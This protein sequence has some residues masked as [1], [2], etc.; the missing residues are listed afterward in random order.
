MES[1]FAQ[2]DTLDAASGDSRGQVWWQSLGASLIPR[3]LALARGYDQAELALGS[4][5]QC[6]ALSA[7]LEIACRACQ[8]D[9]RPPSQK[10]PARPQRRSH[11][12]AF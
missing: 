3:G 7:Q 1:L 4:C 9:Q 11:T 5:T 6:S 2:L 8:L 10:M 12:R